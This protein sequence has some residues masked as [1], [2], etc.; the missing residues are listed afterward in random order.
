MSFSKRPFRSPPMRSTAAVL[1]VGQRVF[2]S[3]LAD[4]PAFVAL[5]DD[6]GKNAVASLADG[7]EV[8]IRAWRPLG[9]DGTRYSV[10]STADG[11]EGWLASANLRG[12]LVPVL[13]PPS[14]APARAVSAPDPDPPRYFGQRGSYS[15]GSPPSPV[16]APATTS[17]AP[18]RTR[19]SEDDGRQFGQRG[20]Y[21]P[22]SPPSPVPAPAVT[23]PAPARTRPS[24]DTGRRFGNRSNY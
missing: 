13:P 22:V 7:T 12:T 11:V 9:S 14:T 15:P 18:V 4:G 3:R 16:P 5:T 10:R 19:Q 23:S 6:T 17:A 2:V 8:E 21:S 20:S 24:E 1:A